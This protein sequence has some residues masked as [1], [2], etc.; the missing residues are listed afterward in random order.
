MRILIDS[1]SDLNFIHPD[2]IKKINIPIKKID[3]PICVTGLCR[4]RIRY[5]IKLKSSKKAN[6]DYCNFDFILGRRTN[7]RTIIMNN[8]DCDVEDSFMIDSDIEFP[9]EI[10]NMILHLIVILLVILTNIVI[11]LLL[12]F[13]K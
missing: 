6:D 12:V 3:N 1:E 9:L 5:A 13:V 4:A 2:S 7:V 10:M 11:V 8:Y